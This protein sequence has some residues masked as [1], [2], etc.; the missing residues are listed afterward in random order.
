M[1][2]HIG[3]SK[4]LGLGLLLILMGCEGPTG[5]AGAPGPKGDTGVAGQDG[6]VNGQ[7]ITFSIR[8]GDF[9]LD[10]QLETASFLFPEI[11]QSVND[12]GLVLVY[13]DLGNNQAFWSAL[14]FV[15]PLEQETVSLSYTYGVGVLFIEII[16]SSAASPGAASI[17]DGDILKVVIIDAVGKRGLSNV[18]LDDYNAVMRVLRR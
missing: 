6:V 12:N 18:D 9:V 1:S 10:Q 17:F 14:P 3:L 8:T 15:L 13:T 4:F 5:P 2:D 16:R 7:V 11:T